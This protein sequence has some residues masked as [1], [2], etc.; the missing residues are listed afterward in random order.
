MTV[1]RT[2][3]PA[4]FE[5]FEEIRNQGKIYMDKTFYLRDLLTGAVV[6]L[7]LRPRRFGKTLSM[8]MLEKFVQIN[9]SNPEDRSRQEKLFEDLAVYED[10]ELCDQFMGRCPAISISL[11][12]VKGKDFSDAMKSMLKLLRNLTS[13]QILKHDKP[14]CPAKNE[15]SFYVI[16]TLF[17][18]RYQH[19]S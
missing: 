8:S 11:K 6:T 3:F 2:D 14:Q 7:L 5:N 9:Y 13:S 18:F 12:S 17:T 19:F 15:R 4:G 16:D 1:S 10:R